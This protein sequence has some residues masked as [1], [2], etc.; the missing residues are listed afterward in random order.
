MLLFAFQSCK[1]NFVG[2]EAVGAGSVAKDIGSGSTDGST[3]RGGG[4]EGAVSTVTCRLL[5][6][7]IIKGS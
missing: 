1:S 3:A 4:V 6:V 7:V 5:F 2:C